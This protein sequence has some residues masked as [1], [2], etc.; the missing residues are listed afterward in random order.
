[1]Q[2]KTIFRT[3]RGW[4][5]ILGGLSFVPVLFCGYQYTQFSLWA[6]ERS[7]NGEFVCGTGIVALLFVC[8]AVALF[9]AICAI[10]SGSIAY[11]KTPKPRSLKRTLE[12]P[13]VGAV[14]VFFL[15]CCLLAVFFK[16]SL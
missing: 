8:A 4:S 1:M 16:W 2:L 7:K 6:S 12:L 9:L 14:L 11:V 10:A 13:L 15:L 5:W 3:F